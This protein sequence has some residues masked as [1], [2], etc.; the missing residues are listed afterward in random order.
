[1]DA[2]DHEH[3]F[4]RSDLTANLRYEGAL[5]GLDF[6]RLQRASEGSRQS[7]AGRGHHVVEGGG[8]LALGLDAIM[9]SD[10]AVDSELDGSFV[11]G[12][13]R[14]A[15]RSPQTLDLDLGSVYDVGHVAPLAH[16]G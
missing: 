9:D 5:V 12:Q 4:V 6:A 8:D 7:A 15:V 2:T 10:P 13:P 14:V 16:Q 1:M 3:P 11:R